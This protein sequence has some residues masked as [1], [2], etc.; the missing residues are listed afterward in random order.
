MSGVRGKK[1]RTLLE[2]K[3]QKLE[4]QIAGAEKLL[5]EMPVAIRAELQR[6]MLIL[7]PNFDLKRVTKLDVDQRQMLA[8][9]CGTIYNLAVDKYELEQTEILLHP[10]KGRPKGSRNSKPKA[11][12]PSIIEALKYRKTLEG[13]KL[14]L[15]QL[16]QK[17]NPGGNRTQWNQWKYRF[18]KVRQKQRS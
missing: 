13:K 18:Q 8:A 14:T 9:Y 5:T 4:S 10:E 6:A 7:G 11:P 3:K 15:D 17:F 2:R 16:A 1:A 12:E